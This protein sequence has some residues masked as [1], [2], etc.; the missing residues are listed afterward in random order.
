MKFRLHAAR[1]LFGLVLGLS[2][3]CSSTPSILLA[4]RTR[5]AAQATQ[6][7]P[8]QTPRPVATAT[9]NATSPPAPSPTSQVRRV[10]PSGFA[11]DVDP[12]TG[13]K[14]ESPALLERRPVGLEVA[15]FP[16]GIRPQ[17][18]LSLAD[19]VFEHATG[20]GTTRFL[21]FYYGRNA[22][23]A[24][25]ITSGQW[26]D[27]ELVRLFRGL[28][29]VSGVIPEV[30]ETLRSQLPG[31]LFNA[32]PSLC[33]GLCPQGPGTANTVFA[34]T[35]AL[36]HHVNQLTNGGIRPDLDGYVFDAG[37]PAG[38]EIA[39]SLR[40]VYAHLN[41][42]GWDFD[43]DSGAYLRSQDQGDSRL[44]PA[45][46]ALTGEQLAF[47]NII[48]LFAP[49]T[50]VQ[51]NLLDISLWYEPARPLLLL[52]SGRL[53]RGT[54]SVEDVDSPLRWLD[55][56]G[57]PLALAPGSTWIEIVSVESQVS[58]PDSGQWQVDFAP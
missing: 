7:L 5:R 27:G 40:V 41:Q 13:L 54:W 46:D 31:R 10:G 32:G 33:P 58:Q 48:V 22:P 56:N 38:G 3:A 30:D 26:V 12:L 16:V 39:D 50:A 20:Q 47:Q 37:V 4:E 44:V 35:A 53:Y 29:G 55:A 45:T 6:I 52:R 51:P 21:A 8:S 19:L 1:A 34:D 28:L 49:H 36:S 42:V 18:G 24:G 25:P 23:S 57:I 43:S 17:S 9:S 2:L 14:V 11:A 15:N